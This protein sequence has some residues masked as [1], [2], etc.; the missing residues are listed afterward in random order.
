MIA[1]I[2][3]KRQVGTSQKYGNILLAIILR[4]WRLYIAEIKVLAGN[5]IQ[6][7]FNLFDCTVFFN[8]KFH[9]PKYFRANT[10]RKQEMF[11]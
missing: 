8:V 3:S 1:F 10:N 11:F 5:Y 4:D 2:P 7:F 9:Q 6:I